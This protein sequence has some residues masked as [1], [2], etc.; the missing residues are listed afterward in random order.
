MRI[1]PLASRSRQSG[2]VLFVALILLVILSLLGVS[3]A[4]MQT[5]EERMARNEDNRQTGAQ[6]AEAALRWAESQI[7]TGNIT[8]TTCD[9]NTNGQYSLTPING[10]TVSAAGVNPNNTGLV[11]WSTVTAPNIMPYAGPALTA[12]PPNAQAPMVVVESLPTVCLP[13]DPCNQPGYSGQGTAQYR[14]TAYGQ[15]GDASSFTILQSIFR[16]D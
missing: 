5:T 2:A 6:A 3:A 14:V 1:A 7:A 13:G 16:G 11:P 8:P 15:G 12:L 9:A 10:S 4:R